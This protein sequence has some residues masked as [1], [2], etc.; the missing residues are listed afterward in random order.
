MYI[1]G[2]AIAILSDHQSLLQ[3]IYDDDDQPLESV[4]LDE[5]TGKIAVCTH[6][7][8][9]I[10]KPF[11]HGDGDL[12]WALETSFTPDIDDSKSQDDPTTGAMVLSWGSSEELLV[13]RSALSLYQTTPDL[14]CTWRKALASPVKHAD[15]SYDS[16]YIA[17]VSCYDRLV[18]VWRRLSYVSDE[19]RFDFMYLSHPEVVTSLHWRQPYHVDQ[20][21]D[22][23]LYTFC[24]DNVLRIWTGS[25]SYSHQQLTLWGKIDFA[26]EGAGLNLQ[27]A[28]IVHGRDISAAA[29]T[30]VQ[31][32]PA[33]Y[34]KGDGPLVNT[35]ELANRNPEICVV[36]D[37][38]GKMSAWAMED[39]AS[40]SQPKKKAN[41]KSKTFAI[42]QNVTSNDYKFLPADG[43]S[44]HVEIQTYC[45]KPGGHLS[46]LMHFLDGRIEFYEANISRLLD[47]SVNANRLRR[48]CVWSGH[49]SS[50]VKTVRNYSGRAV[51]SRTREG[52]TVV[53]KHALYTEKTRLTR[54]STFTSKDHI[55]RIAVLRKGRF[56]V[57]LHHD[58]ASVWDCRHSE[59]SLIAECAYK[60]PG[61]PLCLLVLP[62]R[63]PEQSSVAHI[64]TITS[65]KKGIVWE[66]NLPLYHESAAPNGVKPN[67]QSNG[68]SNGQANGHAPS[69]EE[70]SRFELDDAGDLSYVLPVDPA[71]SAPMISGF[72]DVFARDVAV[73][74]TKGGRVE[75]WTA[76]IGD[77]EVEWLSTASMETGVSEPALA[78]GS[79]MKKAALVNTARTAVTIWDIRGARLEYNQEF[80]SQN[81]I[82]DLDWTST[83]DSQS[84]L[85]VGFPSRVLLLSQMRFDYLNKGPAWAPI[86]EISIRDLTP[87]PIGDS[88]WLGDGNL[89]I[90]AG[91][92]LFVHDRKFDSSGSLVKSIS[93]PH[94]QDGKWD[95]FDVVQRL[96]GP[97]P[98]F[99]PQF[100]SQCMLAGKTL[101]THRI[102]MSLHKTL[103]FW[104]E[105]EPI[106]D[107]LG[108]DLEEFYIG[109][110]SQ[111]KFTSGKEG[112]SYFDEHQSVDDVDEVFS[113][114]VAQ[115]I[116]EKLT[117]IAL[118]Q[119]SGH[120]QFQL[121]DMIECIGMVEKHRRSMD[122]NGARFMIY[123]RQHALRKRRTNEVSMSWR[124]INWAYHSI[125]QD[126]LTDF[127]SRQHHG[128]L[129]WEHARESG[130]FMWLTD[131]AAVVRIVF[132]SGNLKREMLIQT[133]ESAIRDD[134]TE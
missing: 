129:L 90:G 14:T 78:S 82:Q 6:T 60:I 76:S 1:S 104:I 133:Q 72:L 55:H 10:Y 19:V 83:P 132:G 9:R 97:L 50:V 45:N 102:L 2:N 117:N 107:Y 54:Q 30:A 88:T 42:V 127:V 28:A 25:D 108:L 21:V 123:Y 113:E 16:A 134:R 112:S 33:E 131:I 63:T 86:R 115:M 111:S 57:F 13:S 18:K 118:P 5:V 44:P 27:W 116:N 23:V 81:F 15:L 56:V 52:E 106:D 119:L 96:N 24:L 95:L 66:I 98:V 69:I 126:M 35:V 110:S 48:K 41:N 34:G 100:L 29:E 80:E 39:V 36:F 84:I 105:G 64:A 12:K 73:S 130:M 94:K 59:P 17:S 11:V 65:E 89:V 4:A 3:T 32:G 43:P 20:T 58:R 103:K 87:H 8:V 114:D 61:K 37:G 62:R 124:E 99:H 40:K 22:N 71:G 74:Y 91:N 125:S 31:E 121:V 47:A 68:Q 51:V 85:A 79:T 70:F 101:L 46:I 120:E 7:T 77:G 67:G 109:R 75:F 26:A 93:L 128:S 122:E 53:W 49:S 92:Q 38:R